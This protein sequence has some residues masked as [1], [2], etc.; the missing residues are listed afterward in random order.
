MP[1]LADEITVKPGEKA[2]VPA[3]IEPIHVRLL[4]DASNVMNYGRGQEKMAMG[5]LATATARYAASGVR[6]MSKGFFEAGEQDL[7]KAASGGK[8][9]A[10]A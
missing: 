3:V 2:S 6:G 4:V 1:F 7:T 5:T 10:Q 8:A 9:D